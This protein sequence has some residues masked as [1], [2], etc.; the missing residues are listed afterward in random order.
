MDDFRKLLNWI[1]WSF[2]ETVKSDMSI[3]SH[4]DIG[5]C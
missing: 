2:D 4:P 5:L 3:K 1:N